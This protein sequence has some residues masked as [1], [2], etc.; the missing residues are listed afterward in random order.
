MCVFE[1]HGW[2]E[3]ISMLEGRMVYAGVWGILTQRM[4]RIVESIDY[5]THIIALVYGHRN[6]INPIFFF[7]TPRCGDSLL[8]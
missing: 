3:C 6:Q 1:M 4:L 2:M 7:L 8:Y 5:G